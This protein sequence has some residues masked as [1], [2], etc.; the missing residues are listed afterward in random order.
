MPE[1]RGPQRAGV[2]NSST[3]R[4]PRPRLTIKPHAHRKPLQQKL[5]PETELG[6][7]VSCCPVFE[8]KLAVRTH[9]TPQRKEE[10]PVSV[11]YHSRWSVF[12]RKLSDLQRNRKE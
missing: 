11:I 1:G 12:S 10:D 8:F 6:G 9:V 4:P 3:T 7:C 2:P 5:Q